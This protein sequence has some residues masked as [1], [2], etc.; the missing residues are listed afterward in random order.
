MVPFRK[1]SSTLLRSVTRSS[2]LELGR[3]EGICAARTPFPIGG[4]LSPFP[5]IPGS[6]MD[7]KVPVG[8]H[9]DKNGGYIDKVQ[10][11]LICVSASV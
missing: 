4:N 5:D 11:F 3:P 2:S 1:Y 9:H 10:D 6:E 8:R 7:S